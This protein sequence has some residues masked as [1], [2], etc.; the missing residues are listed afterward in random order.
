MPLQCF[1]HR[2]KRGGKNGLSKIAIFPLFFEFIS[3]SSY[4]ADLSLGSKWAGLLL[5]PLVLGPGGLFL[6]H[7]SSCLVYRGSLGLLGF[8]LLVDH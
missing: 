7:F 3:D 2:A 5:I 1:E 4:A 6:G 8:G